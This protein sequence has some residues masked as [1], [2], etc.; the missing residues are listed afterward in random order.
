MQKKWM[1]YGAYGFTGSLLAKIAADKGFKPVLAGRDALKTKR[2]AL[3][4]GLDFKVFS[5]DEDS[6]IEK[7]LKDID[8]LYNLAGPYCKTAPTMVEACLRT[9][10][11]YM[12]LTGD[13]EIYD[14][15]YSLDKVAIENEILIMPGVGFNVIAT[16]CVA[17]HTVQKLSTCD[18]L[19]IVMATQ[20]KP[21]KGTF[22]QMIA[23]LPRGGYEI[24]NHELKRRNIGKSDIKIKYPDKRRTPFSIPIG[25]L[26]ACHKSLNIAN[27]RVHY[28]MSSSWVRMTETMIDIIAKFSGK[29]YGKKVLS[30]FA[31]N[32]I[33]GPDE[34]SMLHDKAYVYAK[35]SSDLGVYA[36]TMIKTPEPYY[37]TALITL[38]VIQKVLDGEYKGALTPVEAFG[39]SIIFE[40]E[41]V[42]YV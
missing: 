32:Y 27:I 25:E 35:A 34:T 24:E 11:H 19:D 10:T 9:K 21:S 30:N 8:L 41:G 15:L 12:D 6:I 17:A 31:S 14:F 39:S 2:L 38:K 20:A 7:N 29:N 5:L 22:K 37:F 40:V 36:E 28:A 1:I 4:L 13:I 3:S 16:E 18:H 26:I 33:K 23:L 42:E